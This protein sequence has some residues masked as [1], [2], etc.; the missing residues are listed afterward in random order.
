MA[1]W[2]L[3]KWIWKCCCKHQHCEKKKKK[4]YPKSQQLYRTAGVETTERSQQNPEP[5]RIKTTEAP[6]GVK[7]PVPAA[8]HSCW[9]AD[10]LLPFEGASQRGT[11]HSESSLGGR[12][13]R[14]GAAGDVCRGEPG[15]QAAPCLTW[16]HVSTCDSAR[17]LC[18][19]GWY[20]GNN[21]C[22][23]N[24]HTHILYGEE[25]DAHA[26][27]EGSFMNALLHIYLLWLAASNQ[28]PLMGH[29]VHLH[30]P[31]HC[32]VCA[33]ASALSA[34]RT[35]RQVRICLPSTWAVVFDRRQS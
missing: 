1:F 11:L 35:R 27:Q 7:R 12:D 2:N 22:E 16:M 18:H 6:V 20:R 31:E 26:A 32:T 28:R 3:T 19:R 33:C 23:K 8:G 17:G 9:C 15:T 14:S 30:E 10:L 21:V 13:R 29:D 25:Q 4:S 34:T 24:A 5:R